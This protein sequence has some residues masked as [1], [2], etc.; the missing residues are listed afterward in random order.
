MP[1]FKVKRIRR[2]ASVEPEAMDVDDADEVTSDVDMDEEELIAECLGAN[3]GTLA[4]ETPPQSVN[5][6]ETKPQTPPRVHYSPPPPTKPAPHRA[7][8]VP[9]SQDKPPRVPLQSPYY[10]K[11][12]MVAPPK[13]VFQRSG[14]TEIRYRSHYG[15]NAAYMDTRTKASALLRS[16][17]G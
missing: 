16:C 12:S 2:V 13:P 4:I 11:P 1:N 5:S 8:P 17:F 15:P 14:S 10:R 3:I 6:P 7:R 9:Y